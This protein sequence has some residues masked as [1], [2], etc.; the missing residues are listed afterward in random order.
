MKTIPNDEDIFVFE[1]KN[2]N[3]KCW[4]VQYFVLFC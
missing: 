3:M 2:L 4:V 1:L